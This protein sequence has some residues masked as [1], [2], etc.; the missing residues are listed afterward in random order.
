MLKSY[1]LFTLGLIALGVGILFYGLF[2]FEGQ[3]N[4][5]LTGSFPSFIHV[6]AFSL[7]TSALL[8]KNKLLF[9]SF[10]TTPWLWLGINIFFELAQIF[11][12]NTFDRNDLFA[13]FLGA[14]SAWGI[15][16]IFGTKYSMEVFRKSFVLGIFFGGSL[17]IMGSYLPG[18]PF[19]IDD[20]EEYSQSCEN[21]PLYLAYTELRSAVKLKERDIE[22]AG[23][24]Y[25]Y[26]QY[27][28]INEPNLGIHVYD[29]ETKTNPI[30]LGFI[31]IPGNIDIAM[32]DDHLYVDSFIDLVVIDFSE[33]DKSLI[34]ELNRK[35][36]VFDYDRYQVFNEYFSFCYDEINDE[37]GVIIGKY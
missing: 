37:K 6:F 3:F 9:V 29:N 7:L 4:T 20:E 34:R 31:N 12:I 24:I 25:L 36:D 13:S 30:K 27:L 8:G 18:L 16:G 35:E 2:R 22:N 1:I 15:L 14:L 10:L 11:V 19:E 17:L 32:K 5:F 23:K 28:L 21:R 33:I 26:K